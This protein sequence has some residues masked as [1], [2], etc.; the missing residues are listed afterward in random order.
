M[1][2]VP[3]ADDTRST[4]RFYTLECPSTDFSAR[5]RR[6]DRRCEELTHRLFANPTTPVSPPPV[7]RPPY[8]DDDGE[9]IKKKKKNQDKTSKI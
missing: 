3:S 6:R 9:K 1:H 7:Y 5:G 8:G 2:F 4:P